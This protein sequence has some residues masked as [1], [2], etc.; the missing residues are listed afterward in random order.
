[1][2]FSLTTI[3]Q[4]ITPEEQ[5]KAYNGIQ[6]G[7]ESGT[8]CG[9]I[10]GFQPC[11]G[12]VTI[13]FNTKKY[14]TGLIR[15]ANNTSGNA[16]RDQQ[17]SLSLF[18]YFYT[19][20]PNKG[21]VLN[22]GPFIYYSMKPMKTKLKPRSIKEY[23]IANIKIVSPSVN[24]TYLATQTSVAFDKF[25]KSTFFEITQVDNV[26]RFISGN[27]LIKGVTDDGTPVNITGTF[28]KVSY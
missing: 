17:N 2:F 28:E 14:S 23:S 10:L 4:M 18:C 9:D 11:N 3:A 6:D 24:L 20:A 27:F 7:R 19:G 22:L 21:I 8:D 5:V 26:E 1:M 16:T 15:I 12:N 25:D 13:V